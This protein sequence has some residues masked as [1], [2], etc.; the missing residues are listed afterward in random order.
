LVSGTASWLDFDGFLRDRAISLDAGQQMIG[1]LDLVVLGTPGG[2]LAFGRAA[3]DGLK[4]HVVGKLD[5]T[6]AE[7]PDLPGLARERLRVGLPMRLPVV[8]FNR[9]LERLVEEGAVAL[10][11][12]WARRPSH[13]VR[14]SE[15]EEALWRH[16]W[17]RLIKE[18]Y[19]PPRVRDI[20]K[21]ME[22]DEAMVRRLAKMAAR[23]GDVEEVAHDHFFARA[24]IEQMAGIAK[25]LAAAAPDSEFSAA[26]F[27][28]RLDNGRKVAIQILE[29]FDRHGFTIRRKDM[30]RINV[31]RADLFVPRAA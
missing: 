22:I 16:I 31:H 25:D 11:R 3:W 2:R 6:H 15:Q 20:A 26:D 12:S 4:S 30:R 28:D 24:V 27:R 21:A 5:E 1:D 13:Q 29:F 18:P 10:D 14:F 19:K 17:P 7:R 23:R 8:V 9:V